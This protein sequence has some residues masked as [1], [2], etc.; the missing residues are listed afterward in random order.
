[1]QLLDLKAVQDPKVNV[2]ILEKKL[3]SSLGIKHVLCHSFMT[4]QNQHLNLG[5]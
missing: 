3:W 5:N 1:M 2:F 4:F